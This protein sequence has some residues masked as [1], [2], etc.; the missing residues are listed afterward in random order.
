[1]SQTDVASVREVEEDMCEPRAQR[2]AYSRVLNEMDVRLTKQ[3]IAFC[4]GLQNSKL[5][6]ILT[7]MPETDM[8][9]SIGNNQLTT[10]L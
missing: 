8:Q 2:H 7:A 6:V 4:F 3:L 10:Y 1:M 9:P 5:D